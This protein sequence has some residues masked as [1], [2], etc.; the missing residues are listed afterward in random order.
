[1]AQS[2]QEDTQ[3][4]TAGAEELKTTRPGSAIERRE[5]YNH[6]KI[7]C[8]LVDEIVCEPA[9]HQKSW[10]EKS[11]GGGSKRSPEDPIY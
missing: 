11:G 3:R 1:M 10:K 7:Y 4:E 5:E 2:E 8:H 9:R 6:R